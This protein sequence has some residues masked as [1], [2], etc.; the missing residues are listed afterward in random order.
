MSSTTPRTRSV[1]RHRAPR[2][3]L[4]ARVT[5]S[6]ASAA[7]VVAPVLGAG[8][9][10]ATTVLS[11]GVAAA[12]PSGSTH[13]TVEPRSRTYAPPQSHELAE[14]RGCESSGRYATNTGNGYYGAYQFDIGTWHGLGLRGLPSDAQPD[15]QDAAASALEQDRGWQPWPACS[16]RLGLVPRRAHAVPPTTVVGT[17]STVDYWHPVATNGTVAQA[18]KNRG[19]VPPFAGTVLTTR[20]ASTYRSDVRLWQERMAERGWPVTVDGYFGPQTQ[21]V[22]LAF[23][24]EKALHV[25]LPGEVDRGVWAAAWTLPVT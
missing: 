3:T 13:P 4:T 5:D 20:F 9:I 12:A 11:G 2:V 23:A 16:A 25:Q 15:L 10:G 6:L 14:L 8:A 1:G 18:A 22:A 24:Q 17:F 21:H 19:V 7:P